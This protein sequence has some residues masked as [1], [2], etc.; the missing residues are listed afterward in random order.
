MQNEQLEK[1]L[2]IMGLTQQQF[3]QALGY[4]PMAISTW[5]RRG[6]PIKTCVIIERMTDGQINRRS[7]RHDANEIWEPLV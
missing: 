1:A 6:V 5:K 3:A 7:L 4:T 2:S